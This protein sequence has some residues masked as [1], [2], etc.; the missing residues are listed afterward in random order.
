MEQI[1]FHVTF[2]SYLEYWRVY[3]IQKC[4]DSECCTPSSKPFRIYL[5]RISINNSISITSISDVPLSAMLTL[6]VVVSYKVLQ[7]RDV[8]RQ[9]Y[10]I[11]RPLHL[12]WVQWNFS[13]VNNMESV[14]KHLLMKS[15][16]LMVSCNIESALVTPPLPV[17]FQ[18]YY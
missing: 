11:F 18:Q 16:T 17:F 9:S 1:Q 4:R 6:F 14:D 13:Y 12:F 15:S 2:S 5:H 7:G 10:S 8:D 3:K